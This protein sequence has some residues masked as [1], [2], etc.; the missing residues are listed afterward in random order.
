MRKTTKL[1][2]KVFDLREERGW[3]QGDLADE[4]GVGITTILRTELGQVK[5]RLGTLRKIA[6]AL[7]TTVE[8]LDPKPPAPSSPV[9]KYAEAMG[10]VRGLVDEDPQKAVDH[11]TEAAENSYRFAKR[12]VASLPS[13]PEKDAENAKLLEAHEEQARIMFD[14]VGSGAAHFG[15]LSQKPSTRSASEQETG[16][17]RAAG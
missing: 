15:G 7:G 16:P 3:T 13:G 2:D 4:A 1:G 8:E 12:H 6:R 14:L 9:D 11:L 10:R 17:E 5:P